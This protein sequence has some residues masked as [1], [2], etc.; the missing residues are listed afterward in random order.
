MLT[1]ACVLF[2]LL[3]LG[4]VVLLVLVLADVDV[5]LDIVLC[6]A[7]LL[8]AYQFLEE[9]GFALPHEL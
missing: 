7:A 3:L 4:V 9:Y 6:I 8:H 2:A 1:H 5:L